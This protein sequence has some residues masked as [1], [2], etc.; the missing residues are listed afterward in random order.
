MP[1]CSECGAAI[2]ADATFC[3]N[4]GVKIDS[5]TE[6][7]PTFEDAVAAMRQVMTYATKKV[8]DAIGTVNEKI[9]SDPKLKEARDTM[10]KTMVQ[11]TEKTEA[12]IVTI[13][14]KLNA[15]LE[16]TGKKVCPQCGTPLPKEAVYCWHCG[17]KIK[18]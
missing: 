1:Y 10:R 15:V 9:E 14:D 6:Q 2:P 8:E 5:K 17:T 7:E 11:A 13:E 3:T 16:E 12:V 18:R 4:C